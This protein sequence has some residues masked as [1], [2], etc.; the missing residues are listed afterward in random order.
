MKT[1]LQLLA[2]VLGGILLALIGWVMWSLGWWNLAF[3]ATVVIVVPVVFFSIFI[4]VKGEEGTG[5]LV[6]RGK[7]EK[8]IIFKTGKMVED[9]GEIVDGDEDLSLVDSIANIFG[10]RFAGIRGIHKVFQKT[11]FVWIKAKPQGTSKQKEEVT[12][13]KEEKD[14]KVLLVR[15]YNYGVIVEEAEDLDELPLKIIMSV[16]AQIVNLKKAWLDTEDWFSALAGV[17]EPAVTEFVGQNRY[18]DITGSQLDTAVFDALESSGKLAELHDLY[19]IEVKDIKCV[20]LDPPANHRET[21]LLEMKATREGEAEIRKQE[22]AIQASRSKAEQQAIE[23]AGQLTA[24][25]AGYYRMPVIS[26]ETDIIAHPEKRSKSSADGG[27]LEGYIWAED[28]MKRDR[29]GGGLRDVRIGNADG[30]SLDPVTSTIASLLSLRGGG[31][32]GSGPSGS[33]GPPLPPFKKR[34]P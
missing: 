24:M 11:K 23:T 1:L 10:Y 8:T 31:G 34:G 15:W 9:D 2:C 6:L 3:L 22:L 14:V 27:Y 21:T 19:G 13:A 26:F 18:K 16:V 25:V 29:A 20:K 7:Y 30:T 5:F 32:G 28:Q 12:E 4:F 17:F 33:G